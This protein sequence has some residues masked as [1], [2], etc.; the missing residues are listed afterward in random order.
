[1]VRQI[2]KIFLLLICFNSSAQQYIGNNGSISFFSEAP[3]EDISA[4]NNR[5]SAVFDATSN[6]LVF[7]LR[8]S[9]FVFPKALMQEHFNENYLESDIYPSAIFIGRLVNISNSKATVQGDLTIHGKTNKIKVDGVIKQDEQRV[10]IEAEFMVKLEDYDIKIPRIVMY[11]IAERI[12]I[13][14][15][16]ELE[17]IK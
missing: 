17:V 3:M 10:N 6:D 9:D 15:N 4:V 1:M 12:D 16:I 13:K 8:I 11:K 7:Q 14:V 2:I 5:V